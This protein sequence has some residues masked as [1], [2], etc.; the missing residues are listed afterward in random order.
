MG[1]SNSCNMLSVMASALQARSRAEH[2]CTGSS[3]GNTS[4][5]SRLL[6]STLWAGKLA[7]SR[8]SNGQLH[9]LWIAGEFRS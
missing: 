3:W 1:L 2:D 6:P 4:S 5:S 8:H 9:Q 7:G